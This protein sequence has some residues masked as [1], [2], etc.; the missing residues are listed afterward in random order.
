VFLSLFSA[1]FALATT[2]V[3]VPPFIIEPLGMQDEVLPTTAEMTS[4]QGSFLQA[5]QS[6]PQV[7]PVR[8]EQRCNLESSFAC[9]AARKAATRA[10]AQFVVQ[11]YVTRHFALWWDVNFE[12]LDV[13]TGRASGL[14]ENEI[15]GDIES[16]INGMPGMAQ[17]VLD[18]AHALQG[19]R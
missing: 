19:K 4:I 8:V 11:G 15:K 18:H 7:R 9:A 6:V 14:W 10:G 17:A 5:L 1:A 13:R 2:L 3:A 12:I 16:V